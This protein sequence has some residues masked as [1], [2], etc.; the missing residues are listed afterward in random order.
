MARL[1]GGVISGVP[2]GLS[3]GLSSGVLGGVLRGDEG[4]G[5]G[6]DEDSVVS[7][8]RWLKSRTE[9]RPF[10]SRKETSLLLV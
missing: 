10:C 6:Q 2:S 3:V 5:L 9:P 1:L 7:I 8:G 4:V